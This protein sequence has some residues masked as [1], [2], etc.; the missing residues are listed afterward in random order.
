M[1][2]LHQDAWLDGYA[3][4]LM[5]IDVPVQRE[6][7]DACIITLSPKDQRALR[8]WVERERPALLKFWPS[9]SGA[10]GGGE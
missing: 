7:F 1:A 10:T 6:A 2:R 4:C 9:G 3:A 5:A 8:G